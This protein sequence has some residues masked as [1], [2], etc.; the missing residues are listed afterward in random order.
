MP[1][2]S[3]R[4]YG[5]LRKVSVAEASEPRTEPV[6]VKTESPTEV[7]PTSGRL[8]HGR[9][10][11]RTSIPFIAVH[12]LPL[13]AIFTGVPWTRVGHVRRHLLRTRM[14]FITAG[15]HRYFA[16]RSLPHEPAVRSS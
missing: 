4:G 8:P 2:G 5:R 12:L 7:V 10:N 6:D 15:Y 11:R 1:Q 14:F 9:V 16:H 13:L 3:E